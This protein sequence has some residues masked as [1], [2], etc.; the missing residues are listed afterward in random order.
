MDCA[1]VPIATSSITSKKTDVETY[2]TEVLGSL[3]IGKV[4]ID[5]I[6]DMSSMFSGCSSLKNIDLSNFNGANVKSISNIFSECDQLETIYTPYNLRVSETLSGDWYKADGTKVSILPR[7][8]AY[9]ILI[10]KGQVPSVKGVSIKAVKKKTVYHCGDILHTDDL[11]V[12][13]YDTEGT[14][15]KISDY[16]TNADK[17]D[18]STA[19]IKPL[20]IAYRGYTTEVP[21]TVKGNE[22]PVKI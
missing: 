12:R 15:R 10:M 13:C 5:E 17:I 3:A 19:G 1:F 21:I 8:L 20:I 22:T 7:R 11:T 2:V 9:S 16:T 14:V 4:S 18:M 6:E